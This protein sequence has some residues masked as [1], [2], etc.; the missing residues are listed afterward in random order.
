MTVLTC[1]KD[2]SVF[3]YLFRVLKMLAT[4]LLLALKLCFS[5]C[6]YVYRVS[7]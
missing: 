7:V 1:L 3:P 6:N 4:E 5:F 2:I